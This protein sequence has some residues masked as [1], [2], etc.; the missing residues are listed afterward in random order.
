M[1]LVNNP[2][3][4]TAVYRPLTHAEWHGWTP[5]D[6]V[7]PWFLF[8]VGVSITLAL[9]RNVIAALAFGAGLDTVRIMGVL[10]RIALLSRRLLARS[11]SRGHIGALS[12]PAEGTTLRSD[13]NH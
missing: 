12:C 10:Q 3:T 2:G 6:F 9:G 8:I 7:F 11:I 4:W 5:T 1:V 13:L